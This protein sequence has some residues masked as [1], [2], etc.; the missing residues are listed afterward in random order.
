MAYIVMASK[1]AL[2]S[3]AASA[4]QE[5]LIAI[6]QKII[7]GKHGDIKADQKLIDGQVAAIKKCKTK[8]AEDNEVEEAERGFFQHLGACRRRTPR[9]RVGLKVSKDASHRDPSDAT[10]RPRS[11]P[12]AFAVGVPQ[13]VAKNRSA[14]GPKPR[15]TRS[16]SSSIPPRRC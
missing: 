16:A 4:D 6:I 10:L 9:T 5:K 1:A 11:S 13:K 14:L 12:S 15:R 8:T 3:L 2:T 7:D